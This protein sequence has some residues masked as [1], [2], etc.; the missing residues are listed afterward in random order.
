MAT[1]TRPD[2]VKIH[3]ESTGEGPRVV[4]CDNLFSIP[5]AFRPLVDDLKRDH[6]VLQYHPRGTGRSTRTGPYDIETDVGDLEALVNEAGPVVAAVG[7]A[8]GGSIATLC[9]VR[10]PELIQAVIA[11]IGPPV[12]MSQ[13]FTDE[14]AM[15]ASRSVNQVIETQLESDYRGIV[16]TMTST[17]NPQATEEQHRH[18]VEV[19][20]E[21][22]PQEA[23]VG[24]WRAWSRSDHTEEAEAL[25]GRLWVL[26]H[27]NM[28]WFP[29]ELADPLRE[30]LPDAHIE[31]VEDGPVSRPDITSAIVRRI[32]DDNQ[33][34]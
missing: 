7:P 20:V 6:T 5:D 34:S 8:N 31:V 4:I 11:P 2:G 24:R 21:Y 10:R 29:T 17:G 3:W 28:P 16:R 27:A 19:Q 33:R 9:A 13:K 14:Q 30:L 12:S 23:A 1:L 25:G 26:L 22:C 32:T 15:G 18:R